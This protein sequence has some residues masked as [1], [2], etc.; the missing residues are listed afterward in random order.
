MLCSC[1]FII[2]KK[3]NKIN[4]VRLT[5]KKT[6]FRKKNIL[7]SFNDGSYNFEKVRTLHENSYFYYLVIVRIF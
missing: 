7:F 5:D 2:V 4:E 1:N 3:F 6:N